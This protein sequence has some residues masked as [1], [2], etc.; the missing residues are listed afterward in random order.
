MRKAGGVSIVVVLALVGALAGGAGARQAANVP[1]LASAHDSLEDAYSAESLALFALSDDSTAEAKAR[2]AKALDRSQAAL[3]EATSALKKGA[4]VPAPVGGDISDAEADD[5][6]ALTDVATGKYEQAQRA[7]ADALEVK[8]D[9]M[10]RLEVQMMSGYPHL[11]EYLIP[12]KDAGPTSIVEWG[13]KLW[14]SEANKGMLGSLDI[15]AP[16][17]R[18]TQA[19]GTAAPGFHSV[20]LPAHSRPQTLVEGP[21]GALWFT[22]TWQSAIGRL[23]PSGKLTEFKQAPGSQPYGI[24]VGPDGALWFTE[25]GF[26]KIGRI[27]TTG[28]VTEFQLKTAG[29]APQQ[30]VV[31]PDHALWFTEY[32]SN[33]IGRIT[34]KGVVREFQLPKKSGPAGI[35]AG[36]DGALW[37]TEYAANKIGRITTAGKI[38]QFKLGNNN[39]GPDG[40]VA[41]PNGDLAYVTYNDSSVGV[42][43]NGK[44]S[45]SEIANGG[46]NPNAITLGPG[47]QLY[48]TEYTANK[49]AR[50]AVG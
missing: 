30:I 21:D 33:K 2:G 19:A 24:T 50:I 15:L 8:D 35:A 41:L 10:L 36:K 38:T 23:S 44:I 39:E 37:F 1:S 42:I 25:L 27:T 31:G 43:A 47:G 4:G 46:R 28:K 9:A 12:V 16:G 18:E 14:F 26:N 3:G 45:E 17:V 40:I 32:L 13:S 11:G 29:A 20:K 6:G 34:T 5:T 48:V 49:I 7:V 22:D